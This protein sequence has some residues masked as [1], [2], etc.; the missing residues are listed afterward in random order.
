MDKLHHSTFSH[1]VLSFQPSAEAM[2]HFWTRLHDASS[3]LP[4]TS[5][6][7]ALLAIICVVV[8]IFNN[9]INN[10]AFAA[11]A[12]ANGHNDPNLIPNKFFF[13]FSHKLKVLKFKGDFLDDFVTPKY[14]T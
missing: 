10:R 3:T 6:I 11:F 2:N 7:V 1:D 8:F 13:S 12:A 4:P 9:Y 5:L 14:N